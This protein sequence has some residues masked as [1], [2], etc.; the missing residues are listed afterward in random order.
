MS[1]ANSTISVELTKALDAKPARVTLA[2]PITRRSLDRSERPPAAGKPG[3][4]TFPVHALEA[5]DLGD[6]HVAVSLRRHRRL[7]RS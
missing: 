4:Y 6:A 3:A 1:D 7:D 2:P 5:S